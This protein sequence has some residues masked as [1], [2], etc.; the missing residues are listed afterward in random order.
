MGRIAVRQNLFH[1]QGFDN[2]Y[3]YL[4]VTYLLHETAVEMKKVISCQ[5]LLR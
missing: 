2:I 4:V 3:D 1:C 5:G